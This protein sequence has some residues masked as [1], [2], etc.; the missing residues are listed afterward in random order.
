[1]T[2]CCGSGVRFNGRSCEREG[3]GEAGSAVS[4]VTRDLKPKPHN[5][6]QSR[7]EVFVSILQSNSG[8]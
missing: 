7:Y 5:P 2:A 6:T 3:V 1:M 4:D 8:V